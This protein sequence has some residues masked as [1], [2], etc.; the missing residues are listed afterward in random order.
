M[1]RSILETHAICACNDRAQ[2]A[3]SQLAFSCCQTAGDA[4]AVSPEAAAH[5]RS[6]RIAPQRQRRFG[7][8]K[9]RDADIS[10]TRH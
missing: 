6:G 7:S 3:S 4:S 9:V 2:A 1:G 5:A 10:G 8:R